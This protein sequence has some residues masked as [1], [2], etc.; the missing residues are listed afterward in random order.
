MNPPKALAALLA[1]PSEDAGDLGRRVGGARRLGLALTGVFVLGFG[2]WGA[3]APLA[4]GSVA[5]GVISPEGSRKTV[6]HLEGGIVAAVHVHDGDRVRRGQALVT[7]DGVRARAAYEAL[8]DKY[9]TLT[10]TMDRLQAEQAGATVVTFSPELSA[11]DPRAAAVMAA[12]RRLFETSRAVRT[13]EAEVLSRRIDQLRE[14]ITGYRAQQEGAA[15]QAGFLDE[16]LAGKEALL[17]KGLTTKPEVLRLRRAKAEITGAA[18]QYRAQTAAAE[19]QIGE[20]RLQLLAL[21]STRADKIAA[22]LDKTRSDL[23]VVRE[24]LAASRDVL[25]RTVVTAPA[26]G[27]V[28]ALQVKT[29]GGVVRPGE[30][31]MDIVPDRDALV[32]EARVP[33]KDIDVVHPGLT[34]QVHLTAFS[35]REQPRIDGVVRTVSADRLTDPR[36]GVAYYLARVEVDRASLR[37]FSTHARLVPGMPADVLIVTGERTMFDYLFEP[38]RN[39]LRRSFHEV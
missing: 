9:L 1:P 2:I 22:E 35:S 12:Q 3:T 18:G 13:A 7:L 17:A 16:E 4:G 33:P 32:I 10:A 28:M 6:Q 34:A 19:Q 21:D 23:A 38:F 26:S 25:G 24:Q 39:V 29:E 20:T 36:T 8:L 5:P 15:G 11:G 14:Q 27:T 31:L 37:R 30:R